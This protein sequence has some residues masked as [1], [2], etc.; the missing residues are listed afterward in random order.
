M[1]DPLDPFPGNLKHHTVTND[2]QAE[3]VS[4]PMISDRSLDGWCGTRAEHEMSNYEV[5]DYY[6]RLIASG[7][8]IHRDTLRGKVRSLVQTVAFNMFYDTVRACEREWPVDKP[9][10]PPIPETDTRMKD[11]QDRIE[12]D[13]TKP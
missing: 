11:G 1:S 9:D 13:F 12:K 10:H 6:E 8:L 5:R 3:Y 7:E 4:K 2:P